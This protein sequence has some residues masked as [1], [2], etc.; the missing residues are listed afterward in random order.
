MVLRLEQSPRNRFSRAHWICTGLALLLVGSAARA[1]EFSPAV[2]DFPPGYEAALQA[3][4]GAQEAPA[5]RSEVVDSIASALKAAQG[6][7]NLSLDVI[8]ER[9]AP[10]HLTIKQQLD[11]PAMDPLRSVF[12]NGCAEL[13][14]H[15]RGADGRVLATVNHQHFADDL[16][17][18]CPAK[19][20]LE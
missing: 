8:M 18:V 3:K 14:G 7:C 16:R 10:S 11:D 2:L 9:V 13:T 1:A 20:P 19:D 5:L 6:D 17:S 12:L 4:Y 15:V